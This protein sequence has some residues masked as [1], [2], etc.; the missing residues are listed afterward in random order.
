MNRIK[1]E[2]KKRNSHYSRCA[3]PRRRAAP[4]WRWKWPRRS[5]IVSM[6]GGIVFFGWWAWYQGWDARLFDT[7]RSE[8]IKISARLHFRVREVLVDGRFETS[9]ADLLRVTDLKVGT[10]IFSFDPIQTKARL[11]QLP[12]VH[13]ATVRRLLPDTILIRI[14]ERSAIALW[15]HKGRF[16]LIDEDGRE[17]QEKNLKRFS[18]LLLVVGEDAPLY[19]A[20]LL[21]TLRT[22]PQLMRRVKAAIRVG[23]RRWNLRMDNGIDVRL[24]ETEAIVAWMRLADYERNHAVLARDIAIVDLRVPDRLILR[25][26][27]TK[28]KNFKTNERNT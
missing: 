13:T 25:R 22:Q 23:G 19:A 16:L 21:D 11:E 12:W 10:P 2:I 14:Y 27:R 5:I 17:I 28:E 4:W 3:V 15:Q 9:C 18:N 6:A 20:D 8:S 7:M 1:K 26:G 24:P